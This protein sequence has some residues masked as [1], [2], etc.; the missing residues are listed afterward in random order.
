[1]INSPASPI[2]ANTNTALADIFS[3]ADIIDLYRQQ[4]DTDV[5][6]YMPEKGIFHLYEC[7]D[8]GYRFYYPKGMDGD[9]LFYADLQHQLGDGYYHKWKFENQLA[10][11]LLQHG[12]K[13]LDI[14][15]GVGNFLTKAK[16]KASAVCGLELNKKAADTCRQNGLEVYNELISHHAVKRQDY[17]HV[18]CTFQVLEHVYDVK[19]FLENAVKVLKKGGK[20]VIGVPNN[21]PYFLGYDKYCTLNLPPHHMGLWNR[22]VFEKMAPFFNLSIEHIEYD[23]K[24]SIK[25]QAYLHAKYLLNIKSIGGKH[26][27]A[28]KIKMLLTGTVTLPAAVYKKLTGGINGS[29]IAVVLKKL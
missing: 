5:S 13:V 15:C 29:H 12:D 24:G 19:D 16:E 14:G 21:E 17:Y 2:T 18:V 9:G 25:T 3:S 20:L 4:L 7:K 28:E 1:V 26:T 6:L 10:Y 11:D 23:I 27:L 22:K 8:T